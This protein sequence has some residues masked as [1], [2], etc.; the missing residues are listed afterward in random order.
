MR[1]SR[2]DTTDERRNFSSELSVDI[3][4]GVVFA[5]QV[6]GIRISERGHTSVV[7]PSAT[8]LDG[9][10]PDD[11]SEMAR[12]ETKDGVAVVVV[13]DFAVPKVDVVRW[14]GVSTVRQ[15]FTV[16]L[17]VRVAR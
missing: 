4:I 10:V 6:V 17:R 2:A 9:I 14:V 8:N 11:L 5:S 13:I 3:S 16:E 7:D 1:D 15:V 12:V